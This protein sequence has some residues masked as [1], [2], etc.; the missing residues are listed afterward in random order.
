MPD[1]VGAASSQHPPSVITVNK[2]EEPV[3]QRRL[4]TPYSRSVSLPNETN[5]F[6]HQDYDK[7]YASDDNKIALAVRNAA[8]NEADLHSKTVSSLFY[9]HEL[10][11]LTDHKRHS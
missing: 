2:S 9:Y 11:P 1:T 10:I 7:G 4:R 3:L 5:A 6:H 8:I